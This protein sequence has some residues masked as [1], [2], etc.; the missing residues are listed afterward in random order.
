MP[1]RADLV[2]LSAC[3]T[4]MGSGW[5]SALPAGDDF[6]GLTRAFLVAG[7]RAVLASLW[8]V[9]DRSTVSLMEGFYRQLTAEGCS[10]GIVV[11]RY[12]SLVTEQLLQGAL[13]C[14]LRHGA[15]ESDITVVR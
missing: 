12:N 11:S 10:F 2:T 1:L 9:D 13:D 4:G 14:L 7:S 15:K 6:V 5:F 8:E 3:Q